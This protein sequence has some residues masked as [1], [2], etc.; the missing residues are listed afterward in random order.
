[1]VNL[2]K[3]NSQFDARLLQYSRWNKTERGKTHV[4]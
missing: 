1:M 3:V 4:N 2:A